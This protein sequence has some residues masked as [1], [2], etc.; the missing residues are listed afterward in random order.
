MHVTAIKNC[1]NFFDTYGGAFQD[2]NVKIVEI[3][4]RD[5]GGSVRTC[6]PSRF[7]Y[8][9]VDFISGKGVDVILEDPYR[10]PF[11]AASV[12]IVLSSSCLEHSEMFWVVFLEAMRIL[13]PH[14]LLYLN[15]PSNGEFHRFP[16]DCW[17]F[18]PD[19]GQALVTWARHNGMNPELLESYT[20]EQAGDV[21]N[22]YVAIFVKDKDEVHRHMNRILPGRE[23]LCNGVLLGIAGLVNY[24]FSPEDK[25]KLYYINRLLNSEDP[26]LDD[27]TKLTLIK[28]IVNNELKVR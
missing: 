17:R 26:I 15:V 19:S 7:E 25:R 13:K 14:G 12:D 16:V 22:D 8:I 3:G 9:G 18:Y 10:L 21:W 28:R 24:Q 4:S 20:S 27:K 2:A 23:D 1:Q 5:V 11:D 6:C